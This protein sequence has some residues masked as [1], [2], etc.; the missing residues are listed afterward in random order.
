MFDEYIS[1]YLSPQDICHLSER[2]E[3]LKHIVLP[4]TTNAAPTYLQFA[5]TKLRHYHKLLSLYDSIASFKNTAICIKTSLCSKCIVKAITGLTLI[6]IFVAH[7][8][9]FMTETVLSNL[10]NI[11]V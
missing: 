5:K 9:V 11:I 4:N 7:A 8:R 2:T 6:Q 1:K 3:Q 10:V